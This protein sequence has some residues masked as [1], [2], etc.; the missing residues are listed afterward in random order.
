MSYTASVTV[1]PE[2]S[3]DFQVA[4][5]RGFDDLCT[6]FDELDWKRYPAIAI[7]RSY[8]WHPKASVVAKELVRATKSSPPG[9]SVLKTVRSLLSFIASNDPNGVLAFSQ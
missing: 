8:G 4:S 5:N 3:H 9:P 1:S 2:E 7:I 6:W